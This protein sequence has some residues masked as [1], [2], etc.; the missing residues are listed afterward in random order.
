MIP[1]GVEVFVGLDPIDLRWG[2]DRLCGAVLEKLGR[3]ARSGA[4]FVFF[5]RHKTAVKVLFFKAAVAMLHDLEA[6]ANARRSRCRFI[7][8]ADWRFLSFASSTGRSARPASSTWT[9][10]CETG[11][12]CVYRRSGS[13]RR[14]RRQRRD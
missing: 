5:G 12:S 1:H 10:D 2:F 6:V 7:R 11:R 13:R 14:G 8:S 3:N 9:F 4:L